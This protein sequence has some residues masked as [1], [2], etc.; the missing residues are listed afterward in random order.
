MVLLL[1][2]TAVLSAFAIVKILLLAFL[3]PDIP[4]TSCWVFWLR[5]NAAIPPGPAPAGPG[6]AVLR[7][8]GNMQR[9]S[10]SQ[11]IST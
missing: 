2:L 7:I 9:S 1:L 8:H 11:V 4:R 3:L 6:M 5:N 10:W